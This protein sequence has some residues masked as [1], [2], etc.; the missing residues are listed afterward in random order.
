MAEYHSSFH[1]KLK[2]ITSKSI[3]LLFDNPSALSRMYQQQHTTEGSV[4]IHVA[5]SWLS[6]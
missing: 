6:E 5:L 4:E 3:R 1:S 2:M